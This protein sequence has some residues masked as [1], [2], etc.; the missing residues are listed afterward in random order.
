MSLA[1]DGCGRAAAGAALPTRSRP[2]GSQGPGGVR[3]G[4]VGDQPHSELKGSIGEGPNHSNFS[5]QSSVKILAKIQEFS[6]ENSKK[7]KK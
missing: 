3:H 6:P 4:G 1:Q 5:D 2:G 7:S